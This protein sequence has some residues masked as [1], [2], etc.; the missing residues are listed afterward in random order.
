MNFG[1]KGLEQRREGE[2]LLVI[3]QLC[4][5]AGNLGVSGGAQGT[6]QS[7]GNSGWKRDWSEDGRL[8]VA[9]PH[10]LSWATKG[11][12]LKSMDACGNLPG[13]SP[14]HPGGFGYGDEALTCWDHLD[15]LHG[16]SCRIISGGK[17]KSQQ[18][19]SC[20]RA[21]GKMVPNRPF[22]SQNEASEYQA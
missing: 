11:W 16:S 13:C 14:A 9:I 6:S 19:G 18:R 4:K 2:G 1:G 21:A 7:P 8:G 3:L 12:M 15:L 20:P 5:Q 10:L 17:G 22:L